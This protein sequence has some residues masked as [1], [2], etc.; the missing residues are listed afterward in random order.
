MYTSSVGLL[1]PPMETPGCDETLIQNN[2][3]SGKIEVDAS[4]YPSLS[5]S[6]LTS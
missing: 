2:E 5:V 4:D 1:T 3:K 6:N